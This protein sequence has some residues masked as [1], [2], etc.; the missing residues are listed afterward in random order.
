MKQLFGVPWEQSTN[1][2]QNFISTY[3]EL[4]VSSIVTVFV[5]YGSVIGMV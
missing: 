2:E 3:L 5:A 4:Q 1:P